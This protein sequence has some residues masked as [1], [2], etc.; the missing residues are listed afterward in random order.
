MTLAQIQRDFCAFIVA[1]KP[2]IEPAIA[3]DA[4]RGLAVYHH[5]FRATLIACLR[6]TYEKTAAWLGEDAFETAALEH[7]AEHPPHSWTL[8]DYGDGF[9]TT[10]ASLYRADPEVEE[11]AW[12]DWS[13]RRAFDGI[14]S[15]VQ[16]PIVLAGIDWETAVLRLAP[17]LVMRPMVTNCVALWNAM[18]EETT[19]PA[20]ARLGT[21]HA[22][23]VWRGDLSPRFRSLDAV[24]YRALRRAADGAPFGVLCA[25][26]AADLPN[27][28]DAAAF[29]G[30]LLGQWFSEKLV[31]GA[32]PG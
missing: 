5:A 18:A 23:A 3:V 32:D 29:V 24:E 25:E 11:V 22:L 6:D 12:L 9:E 2:D 13:L 28:D 27:P 16:D 21:F 31:I 20:V 14:D 7:I 1:A 10:L 15:K 19:P 8:N 17:T 4:H 30:G 26:L